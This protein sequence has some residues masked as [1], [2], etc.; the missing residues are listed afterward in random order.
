MMA[1]TAIS[2][3]SS[4]LDACWRWSGELEKGGLLVEVASEGGLRL[5]ARRDVVLDADG[6]QKGALGIPHDRRGSL[7]IN[8]THLGRTSLSASLSEMSPAI[9][10]ADFPRI[11]LQIRSPWRAGT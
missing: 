7:S 6:M 8:R 4:R 1:A 5:F 9:L 11:L 10:R 2:C 3:T